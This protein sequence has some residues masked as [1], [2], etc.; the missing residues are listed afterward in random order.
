MLLKILIVFLTISLFFILHLNIYIKLQR[1]FNSIGKGKFINFFNYNYY[2]YIS[3]CYINKLKKI[4][5]K[6]Y[7]KL[8]LKL[9]FF[10]WK[11]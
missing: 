4:K 7:S 5:L 10:S 6:K 1:L 2:F 3:V 11:I 9:M 8:F